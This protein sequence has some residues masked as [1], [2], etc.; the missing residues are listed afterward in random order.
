MSGTTLWQ[1]RESLGKDDRGVIRGVRVDGNYW[2]GAIHCLNAWG[3][4]PIGGDKLMVG[5]WA[6]CW[7]FGIGADPV[8]TELPPV[9]TQV[10]QVTPK[11]ELRTS[12]IQR[13]IPTVAQSE[14]LPLGALL[15]PAGPFAGVPVGGDSGSIC[16][17]RQGDEW[18]VLGVVSYGYRVELSRPVSSGT[19][20]VKPLLIPAGVA[21]SNDAS[22]AALEAPWRLEGELG[23]PAPAQASAGAVVPTISASQETADVVGAFQATPDGVLDVLLDVASPYSVEDIAKIEVEGAGG[24]KWVWPPN[25]SNWDLWRHGG[26][27]DRLVLRFNRS[28]PTDSYQV[29]L[30]HKL[31]GIHVCRVAPMTFTKPA[32]VEP[33]KPE[34]PTPATPDAVASKA[35]EDLQR[36][37]AVV[38]VELEAERKRSVDLLAQ[39]QALHD[40]N[41][42]LR[43]TLAKERQN[44]EALRTSLSRLGKEMGWA[45]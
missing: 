27:D 35:V 39:N 3:W 19:W 44:D 5:D 11:G 32:V 41:A 37:L 23:F 28:Q 42:G 38:R 8:V 14:V 34:K 6:F 7:S 10:Y 43:E 26:A 21:L 18:R 24:D 9:G 36:E 45:P 22:M 31:A 13:Y 15:Y 17:V 20:A 16:F 12:K 30:R 4:W 40:E 1:V 33:E 29:T 2:T 25:G